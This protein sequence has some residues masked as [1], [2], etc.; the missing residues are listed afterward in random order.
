MNLEQNELDY[1]SHLLKEEINKISQ[2]LT[3]VTYDN[4][5]VDQTLLDLSYAIKVLQR[6]LEGVK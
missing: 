2:K 5:E 3:K 4:E 6:V 1:F